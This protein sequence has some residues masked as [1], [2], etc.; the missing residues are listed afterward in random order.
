MIPFLQQGVCIIGHSQ[1]R[2]SDY[3]KY[4][5]EHTARPEDFLVTRRQFLNRFGM[6]LGA[7]GLAALMGEELGGTVRA[8]E[9]NPLSPKMPPFAAKAKRVVHIFAQG[10]PSQVD[11]WDPK[12]ALE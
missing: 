4:L 5:R 12:P 7:L 6:G 8:A 2:M 11:T 10:A 9:L 1:N 3:Q